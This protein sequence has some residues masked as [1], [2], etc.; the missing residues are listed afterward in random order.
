MLTIGVIMSRNPRHLR[1]SLISIDGF[2]N[3]YAQ[4]YSDVHC[5]QIGAND[6]VFDDPIHPYITKYRWKSLLIEPLRDIFESRLKKTY[7]GY[8][9]VILENYAIDR[10]EGEREI[11]KIGF[12]DQK[13]ALG[14]T[15]FNKE[16]IQKHID[17]GYIDRMAAKSNI[18]TPA[19]REDYIIKE[20]VKTTSPSA[21]LEKHDFRKLNVLTIDTEG[22]D[23]EV[24]KI[25]DFKTYHPDIILYESK[26][27]SD[28]DFRASQQYLENYGYVLHWEKGNTLAID[29][30]VK[31]QLPLFKKLSLK[32]RAF[33]KKL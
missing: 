13:W 24:L 15:G 16:N 20:K 10:V 26:H 18:R 19:N 11:Y 2:I 17:S 5:L 28:E 25:M 12:T 32:S 31:A 7:E 27:L 23:F 4:N 6:G 33:F 29:K 30:K 14:L 1:P 21:L 8:D 22:F 3:Y 9:N